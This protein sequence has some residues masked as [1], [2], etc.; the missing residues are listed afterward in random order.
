MTDAAAVYTHLGYCPICQR[1]AQFSAQHEWHRD[2]L[3]CSGC[4]SI[5][6]ERGV[7]LVLEERFARWRQLRIHESSPVPRG[8]SEKLA[9]ECRGYVPSQ[10]F[11]DL[12]PGQ[13]RDGVRNEDLERQTFADQSF[14]LVITLDVMEHVNEPEACFREIWRTLKPGGAYLFAAPTYKEV[15]ASQRVA[16]FLPDGTIEHYREPEYHGNPVDPRGSLMT[17]RYGYDLPELIRT[18]AP[19]DTRVYRF[20]DHHHGLIGEFTEI[21]LC[22]R[23]A[24]T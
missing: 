7:A 20:H 3:L 21:Y 9:R 6:R 10:F 16:R 12:A 2:H 4:G 18:W 24:R 22:E 1:A 13:S 14:D 11:A 8:V 19:F 17:F 23:R 15:I 5:P